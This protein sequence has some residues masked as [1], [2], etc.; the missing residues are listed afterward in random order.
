MLHFECHMSNSYV[1]PWDM[2]NKFCFHVSICNYVT[3]RLSHVTSYMWNAYVDPCWTNFVFMCKLKSKYMELCHISNFAF[4]M[5]FVIMPHVTLSHIEHVTCH[6]SNAYVD[7][8]DMLN[9][10]CFHVSAQKWVFVIMSHVTFRLSHVACYM[11]NA[12][13]ELWDNDMELFHKMSSLILMDKILPYGC[14]LIDCSRLVKIGLP[15]LM[16]NI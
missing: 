1:D 2:L 5:S 11:W 12:Y 10:F 7:L 8:W 9:N 15:F 3:F 14:C 16:L 4:H 13:V 6:M